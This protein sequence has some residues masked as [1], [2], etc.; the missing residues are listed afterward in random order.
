MALTGLGSFAWFLLVAVALVGAGFTDKRK[1]WGVRS[2]EGFPFSP[3]AE[4]RDQGAND[5]HQNAKRYQEE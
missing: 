3:S 1:I 4:K 2:L 5:D